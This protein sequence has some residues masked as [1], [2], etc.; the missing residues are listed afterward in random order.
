MIKYSAKEIWSRNP[1]EIKIERVWHLFGR[2]YETCITWLLETDF[3][4]LLIG[5]H[6]PSGLIYSLNVVTVETI[7]SCSIS[8]LHHLVSVAF[9]KIGRIKPVY[10]VVGCLSLQTHIKRIPFSCMH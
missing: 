7:K 5:V 4:L 10:Q 1:L 9:T 8:V 2:I 3:A 6:K